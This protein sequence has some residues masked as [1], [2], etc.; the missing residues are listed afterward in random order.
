MTER[1]G[2]PRTGPPLTWDAR[3]AISE[4]AQVPACIEFG[5]S[6][7]LAR[8]LRAAYGLA[9]KRRAR[10]PT[11]REPGHETR[12]MRTV[13]EDSSGVPAALAAP[14]AVSTL[15]ES[16]TRPPCAAMARGRCQV[17]VANEPLA[18]EPGEPSRAPSPPT[19]AVS[20]SLQIG[21]RLHAQAA[22]CRRRRRPGS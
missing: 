19:Q 20:D 1:D 21:S 4:I 11:E 14:V 16:A 6:T 3:P 9:G 7:E 12:E 13:I 5:P 18:T 22:H 8:R 2:H 15:T 10:S 17:A